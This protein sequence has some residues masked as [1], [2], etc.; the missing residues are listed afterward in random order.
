MHDN[1]RT[2]RGRTLDVEE[3]IKQVYDDL[4][5]LQLRGGGIVGRTHAGALA[6]PP[7]MEGLL[8]LGSALRR[9]SA[10]RQIASMSP[11]AVALSRMSLSR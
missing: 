2:A 1:G 9:P 7:A 3:T 4:L 10:S 5:R 11:T 8:K 6:A